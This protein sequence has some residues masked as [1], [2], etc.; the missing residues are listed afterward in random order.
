MGARQSEQVTRAIELL[1]AD[2]KMTRYQAAKATGVTPG[3]LY[4]S[5]ACRQLMAQRKE[6][7]Q[8]PSQQ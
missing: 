3:A 6:K 2:P 4:N 7:V 1:R 8:N 5:I